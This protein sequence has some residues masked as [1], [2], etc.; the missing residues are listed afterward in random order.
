M[1]LNGSKLELTADEETC[2]FLL[3]SEGSCTLQM[4]ENS[5]LVN[6]GSALLLGAGD[7]VLSAAGAA[8][9]ELV[10]CRFPL[11][12]L[13]ELRS[14]TQRDFARLFLPGEVTVLYGPVPWVRRLRT[15]LEMMRAAMPEQDYPGGLYLLLILHHVEQECLAES[16]AAARPPTRPLSRCVP[17]LPPTTGKSSPLPRWRR[18]STSPP[19][20]SAA[21]SG[22]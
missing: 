3:V 14:A 12:A 21:C 13:H 9:P 1:R 16:S 20:I 5:L 4:G 17:T 15:L 11:S 10:G 7:A 2:T 6:P 22:G 18:G 19:T 8:V